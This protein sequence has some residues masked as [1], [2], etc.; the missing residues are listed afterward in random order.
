V[1]YFKSTVF[2]GSQH[3]S[4]EKNFKSMF[5]STASLPEEANGPLKL[6]FFEDIDI[7]FD[8]EKEFL[9]PQLSKLI[10]ASK[11]PIILSATSIDKVQ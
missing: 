4:V 8:D 3:T 7:I 10:Q 9:Y 11:V 5:S 2:E 1:Q 6:L